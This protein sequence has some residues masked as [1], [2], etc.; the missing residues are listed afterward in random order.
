MPALSAIAMGPDGMLYVAA[1]N[2]INRVTL[3]GQVTLLAEGF[4]GN[5]DGLVFDLAGNLHVSDSRA[6]GI[7]RIRGFAAG[8][9]TGV[10]MDGDGEPVTDAW[11]QVVASYPRVVGDVIP[12]SADGSFSLD[13]GT[14]TYTLICQCRWLCNAPA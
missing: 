14:R 7:A 9:I 3:D 12:V 11:V 8:S 4:P 10:V 6:N 2:Q 5:P 1:G 13:V